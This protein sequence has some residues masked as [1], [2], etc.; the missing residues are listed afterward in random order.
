MEVTQE[1]IEQRNV[2]TG[3]IFAIAGTALFSLKSVLIK[4]AFLEG[5]D[6]TTLLLMRMIIALPFYLIILVYAIKTRPQKAALLKFSDTFTIVGLGFMGYYL[7]SYLDFAG[8]RY[9]TA[10]LERLT[11]FTYPVMVAMLS[12]IFFRERITLKILASL[13]VS[14][15]GVGFLFVNE[16]IGAGTEHRFRHTAGC[17]CRFEFFHVR[18]F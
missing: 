6:A 15:L 7:A 12:W 11:L 17:C 18:D 14:Y 5:I 10:Q 1:Q 16:S 9:I 13:V 3:F 4:L 8:L 2:T